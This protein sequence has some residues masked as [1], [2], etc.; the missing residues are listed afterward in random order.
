[1]LLKFI[2][3]WVSEWSKVLDSKSTRSVVLIMPETLEFPW[4]CRTLKIQLF[5][6]FYGFSTLCL[7]FYTGLCVLKYNME[8]YRSGHNEPDSKSGCP[9]GHV[10]SNLTASARG[11]FAVN[12]RNR[13]SIFW[14]FLRSLLRAFFLF[15][16]K[17]DMPEPLPYKA[18][19]YSHKAV[20][21]K[22]VDRCKS[23]RFGHSV[24]FKHPI[25]NQA[26]FDLCVEVQ[27]RVNVRCG[28][29]GAV[30]QPYLDLLH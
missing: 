21:R 17:T 8:A 3:G 16:Q 14:S 7:G 26:G 13:P 29:K 11:L 15:L 25:H 12:V 30:P 23:S 9:H 20:R 5:T 2:Y 4:V 22:S 1:M 10:S 18:F 19:P 28:R 6:D 27:M 24:P